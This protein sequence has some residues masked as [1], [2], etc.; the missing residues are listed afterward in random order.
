MQRAN[1]F[2]PFVATIVCWACSVPR[3]CDVNPERCKQR[4]RINPLHSPAFRSCILLGVAFARG[5]PLGM[6]LSDRSI[7]S[8]VCC[9]SQKLEDIWESMELVLDDDANHPVK[10]Y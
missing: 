9:S 2:K 8:L 10:I 3:V 5:P 1:V 6:A 7:A 4:N